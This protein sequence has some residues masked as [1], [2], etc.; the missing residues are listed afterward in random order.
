MRAEELLKSEPAE[1]AA[2]AAKPLARAVVTAHLLHDATPEAMAKWLDAL[3]A[4]QVG[5]VPGVDRLGWL[6]YR[7]GRYELAGRWLGV[8]PK[9][10]PVAL[11]L[12]AKLALRAGDIKGGTALLASAAERFAPDETWSYWPPEYESFGTFSASIDPKDLA[13]AELAALALA[14]DEFERALDLLVR[15][16]Y[17]GDAAYVAERLLTADQLKS[18][19]DRTFPV[20][21][22]PPAS[23]PPLLDGSEVEPAKDVGAWLR[24]LLARRLAREGR[25]GEA[26]P[27]YPAE[28]VDK[29]R[30]LDAALARTKDRSLGPEQRSAAYWEAAKLTRH[31][32]IDLMGTDVAPDWQRYGG[33]FEEGDEG[34]ARATVVSEVAPVT[35]LEKKRDKAAAPKP[36]KRF[37][38]RY[39]ASELA[40]KAARLLPK[41]SETAGI[42]LCFASKWLLLRDPPAGQA[43]YKE[44]MRR[45]YMF[46]R[47]SANFGMECPEP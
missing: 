40:A 16:E 22:P 33:S 37:H 42:Y 19:V 21:S 12:R 3:V 36:D 11:W 43:Y 25:V 46:P 27:Y 13:S 4:A 15:S 30:A 17:D 14:K 23:K 44:F 8:A 32:G 6:A 10:S 34:A 20:G 18:Y 31:E 38:Y 29:A 39:V 41:S 26:L 1:L 2:V 9:D 28:W 5:D 45:N 35:K 24:W 47:V 7:A